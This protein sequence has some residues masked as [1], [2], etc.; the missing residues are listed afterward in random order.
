MKKIICFISIAFFLVLQ[1]NVF[2][3]TV[4]IKGYVKDSSNHPVANKTVRIY[5]DS[6]NHSCLLAHTK[7]TN[8]NGYYT[9]TLTC[10]GDIRNLIII[11]EN[12]N[13]AK[14]TNH[15]QV[16]G[17]PNIVESN[18]I[19]CTT[20]PGTLIPP[21]NC[22][23]AFSYI[24]AATGIKFNG[25]GSE[26]PAGDSITGRIWSFGDSTAL[27]TGNSVDPTHAYTKPGIYTVCLYIKT[28]KG[29]ES[30]YCNTVVFTPAS[31]DCNVQ[32][33]I[34]TEKVSA[35][36][37]RFNSGL[38]STLSGDSIVQRIWKF[39]DNT[40]LDGNQVNPLKEY[41]DTGVY[42]VCVQVRTAKGCEK[43]FCLSVVVRDSMGGILPAPTNCKASFTYTI[44][45]STIRFNSEGSHAASDDDSI[46]S[47][48]WYYGDNS[49]SVSLTGN[50]INPSHTYSKPGSYNVYLVIK[51]KKGCE[52]KYSATVVIRPGIVP[53]NC[54]AYFNYTI[55]DSTIIFN[56]EDS[57]GSSSEDSIISRTWYYAD[58]TNAVSLT[59][60]VIKPSYKYS[61]PGSYHVYLVIK[62]KNGCESKY[63]STVVIRPTVVPVNCKAYFNYTIK[64]STIIFNSEDSHGSSS[65]DSIISRIW[66]YADSANS[67][68]LTGNVIK[69]SYKYSKPGTYHVYLVIKT[70]NGCE[71]KYE[72]TVVIRPNPVPA[73]CKAVFT[74]TIQNTSVKFNS[75]GSAATSSEDSIINRSWLFGDST[76]GLSGNNSI[77][78][79]HIY[80]KSG[81]YTVYLYIKPKQVVKVNT[82][83]QWLLHQL[84]A[85]YRFSSMQKGLV[86][87]KYSST[88]ALVQHR[89]TVLFSATGSLVII[90]YSAAM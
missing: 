13:G 2:A 77:D 48:T 64:D 67:V 52:S 83:Q 16:V 63:E 7:V 40:S 74:F 57:H 41:K 9:D 61:K 65:E 19:I 15:P 85:R 23:A 56:S 70:K 35:K 87:K 60:N 6:S 22:H 79:L 75:A 12:C 26:A 33:Q 11:V 73:N 50:V 30:K 47:R 71:S 90:P 17:T 53:A 34:K 59:G 37:I 39:G 24:S 38:S 58:S 10:D 78:P 54:K 42:Y 20:Q 14:I 55:K 51:T 62:T 25:H 31:N 82:Q 5:S 29:C 21:T 28:K 3:N 8:P 80:R 81:T 66:Y 72:S 88:A 49:T 45:D 89:A 86:A 32:L 4:I 43:T 68:S 46:I 76:T 18:F 27:L 84:T 44:K 36:K 69:P 1:T